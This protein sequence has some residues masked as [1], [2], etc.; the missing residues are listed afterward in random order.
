MLNNL[1]MLAE[2]T[3]GSLDG[4]IGQIIGFVTSEVPIATVVAV[5]GVIIAAIAVPLFLWKFGR[6][7]FAAIKAALQGKSAGI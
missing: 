3:P 2:T 1:I 5:I 7:G 6:K 4:Y